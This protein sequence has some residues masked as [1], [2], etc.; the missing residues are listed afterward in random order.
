MAGEIQ[1]RVRIVY[2]IDGVEQATEDQ[3]SLEQALAQTGAALDEQSSKIDGV[4]R[5]LDGLSDVATR[6]EQAQARLHQQ[7][8]ALA[9]GLQGL[10]SILGNESDAGA[11]LGR[12]GQFASVGIQ[13]G[14]VFGPGGAV[15]GGIIGSAIPAL[16]SLGQEM[17][18]LRTSQ[19]DAASSAAGHADEI[20][21]LAQSARTAADDL[22]DLNRR[23]AERSAA[24]SLGRVR[25]GQGDLTEQE[26]R[27]R[28][29][30]LRDMQ[31]EAERRGGT[32]AEIFGGAGDE[33]DVLET[34]LNSGQGGSAETR[35]RRGGG[36]G[37]RETAADRLGALMDRATFGSDALGFAAGLDAGDVLGRPS[38]FDVQVAGRQRPGGPGSGLRAAA[39]EREQ[40]QALERL[41]DKQ[42]EAHE[43]QMARI[44]QQV[45]AWTSAGERIGGV[46]AGA[47]KT[48]IQGQEDFGVA[49]IKG[50]KSIAVE[51]GGQ[52][53]A[54][55][56]GALF[57][58]IG[59]TILNPP[60]AATKA[61]EGAGKIALG[62]GLGAAGAAIPVPSAGG[63][64]AKPPR[65]G[66]ASSGEG[67]G[68]S[69]TYNLNA[70][71]VVTGTRAELG[72]EMSRTIRQSSMRFG[73]AA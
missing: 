66:P 11:L 55:G 10:S 35:R 3:V 69:V 12:M 28:V 26:Q 59:N 9:G 6:S 44:Q 5:S 72:R 39:A 18:L 27:M 46:I 42:K 71:A 36:R 43:E 68:G 37:R 14:S 31:R 63:G 32:A 15:V 64:Q 47:F 58:A 21:R 61:A 57:T 16:Q 19:D 73:R 25:S 29:E 53:I 45:D 30:A 51:F 50:F 49:V 65:L 8:Q 4:E 60:A 54:E 38:D 48:A 24:E 20:D 13:L 23:L 7:A 33:A 52:M 70:P 40:M 1:R 41:R 67:G 62:V 22:A 56:V 34:L 2:E 17:G